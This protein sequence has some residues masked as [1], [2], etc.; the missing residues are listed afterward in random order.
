V[1]LHPEINRKFMPYTIDEILSNPLLDVVDRHDDIGSFAFRIG[2]L[3]T[4]VFIE[5]GRYRNS[6]ETK[7]SASH[8]IKTPMQIGA[9]HT[10]LP[11][12]DSWEEALDRAVSGLTDYYEQAIKAGHAPSDDWLIKD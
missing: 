10:S 11:F 6:N 4:I 5:L 9:Y 2:K 8:A 12:A 1:P 3:T 7:F